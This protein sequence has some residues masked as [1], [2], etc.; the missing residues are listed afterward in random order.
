MLEQVRH[1]KTDTVTLSAPR[2]LKIVFAAVLGIFTSS[3][4]LQILFAKTLEARGHKCKFVLCD[5]QLPL[6]EVTC[7]SH[8]I[9]RSHQCAQC[10]AYG[11]K[12]FKNAGVDIVL[13]SELVD[14]TTNSASNQTDWSEFINA[15]ALRYYEVGSLTE[16][17]DLQKNRM[18]W[19]E[20]AEISAKMGQG[21]VDTKPDRIFSS[22]GS[23][24]TRGPARTIINDAGIPLVSYDRGKIKSTLKFNWKHPSDWW[25]VSDEWEKVKNTPLTETEE[26]KIDNYLASRRTH[27]DDMLVYNFGKEQTATNT[28]ERFGFDPEKITYAL[29]TNV[30]WD[31]ASAQR[32]IAFENPIEW[33][34]ET[35]TWFLKHPEKQLI[36]KIHPAEVVIGTRQPFKDI[37]AERFPDMPA[38]IKVIPPDEEVNSWS[39]IAVTDIGLVH[40]TTVG[41]ELPLEGIPCVVVSNTHYRG[42]G[43]T[44]DVETP[45]DYV[46]I[47]ETFN[48]HDV[49]KRELRILS[50]RYAYLL[51]FRYQLPM[52]YVYPPTHYLVKSLAIEN[53]QEMLDHP[54]MQ[55]F[56]NAFENEQDFLLPTACQ[57]S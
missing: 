12:L 26:S 51:F 15:T 21:I 41:M 34:F 20:S 19:Q 27:S 53:I 22:H 1:L 47:L 10:Y 11:K 48:P 38:N 14:S 24:T 40:T 29:F 28:R 5:Q 2:P 45:E 44:I 32:E 30:L 36:V 50:K 17:P 52:P 37:I 56:I 13:V 54:S 25:D 35:I 4:P 43:F 8:R 23:Y 7:D 18:L 42:K 57:T 16:T 49:K 9:S 39:I 6:C 46:D 31:A 55:V 33:V 3:N